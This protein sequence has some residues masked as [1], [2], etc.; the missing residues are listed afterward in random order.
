MGTDL[1]YEVGKRYN[2]WVKI[3]D[4]TSGSSETDLLDE[5]FGFQFYIMGYIGVKAGFKIDVAVGILSTSI[6]S[7]GANVEFGPY[8]KLYGYFLYIYIKERP[9]N[10]SDWNVEERAEGAMY[11]EFGLYLTVKFK[12][13]ALKEL[14]K[15]EPTLYDGEFPLLTA[16][17]QKS[18]YDFAL[19]PADTD[20]LYILDENSDFADGITMQ[21]PEAYRNMKTI[22]LTSGQKAQSVYDL[23]NYHIRFTDP[24]FSIDDNGTLALT[25]PRSTRTTVTPTPT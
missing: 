19:A 8:V 2:F 22:D 7:V 11:V 23:S 6:A 5:R 17:E 4:G 18:V 3:F 24:A 20:I 25:R 14:I 9:A 15:Y 16:G 12:A 21:L 13:Q 10:T 1:E